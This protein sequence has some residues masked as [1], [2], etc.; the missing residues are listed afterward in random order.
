MDT[1]DEKIREVIKKFLLSFK[2]RNS[3]LRHIK[4]KFIENVN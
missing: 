3:E 1:K 2:T 4:Q